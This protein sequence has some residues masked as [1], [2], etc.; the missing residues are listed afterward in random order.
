MSE[1]AYVLDGPDGVG[2]PTAQEGPASGL[3]ERDQEILAFERQWWKYSGA[4]EQAV[5]ELFDMTATRYY[6]VLNALIDSPAALAHDPMLVKR[7]RRM[8]S[9]RQRARTARRLEGL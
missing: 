6:Q 2:D 9:T 5:R 3:S 1:A 4:K 7:L 8:R